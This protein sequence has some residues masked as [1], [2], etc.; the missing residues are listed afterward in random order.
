MSRIEPKTWTEQIEVL[1]EK[2]PHSDDM[3]HAV[4]SLIECLVEVFDEVKRLHHRI[5]V[6]EE[7]SRNK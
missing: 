2:L 4:L 6:L 7:K 5:A 3:A 1:R